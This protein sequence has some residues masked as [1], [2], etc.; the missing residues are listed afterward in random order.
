MGLCLDHCRYGS[1][2]RWAD[3]YQTGKPRLLCGGGLC[4]DGPF[5][6]CHFLFGALPF[7]LSGQIPNYI[8]CFFET[9]SG[10]TTTGASILT[11]VEALSY[12]LLYWRSFTHWLGG[13]GVL[14]FLLAVVS[15]SKGEGYSLYLLKAESPGP[16][17][18]K[19]TPRLKQSAKIL[20]LIYVVLTVIEIIFL[21]AGECP[22]STASARPLVR[23]VPAVSA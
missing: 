7:W 14:V 18:G 20:Y 2:R 3:L 6:D 23:R 9:A 19:M 1:R 8:D 15:V 13:M 16:D 17:V 12:G 4:G 5:L 21:L 22:Y 11:D 10:F